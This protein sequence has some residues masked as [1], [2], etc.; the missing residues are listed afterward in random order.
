M[1]FPP[2]VQ[3]MYIAALSRDTPLLVRGVSL[4]THRKLTSTPSPSFGVLLTQQLLT[5][6]GP[7]LQTGPGI[8]R[9]LD[10]FWL[11]PT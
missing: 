1:S 4:L 7:D 3:Y 2:F 9:R 10:A 11:G 5:V 8:Y 6:T